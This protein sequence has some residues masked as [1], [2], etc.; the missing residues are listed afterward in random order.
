MRFGVL[1][2]GARIHFIARYLAGASDKIKLIDRVC[3][4][5]S[6]AIQTYTAACN[7]TS[8]APRHII[9]MATHRTIASPTHPIQA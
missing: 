3:D 7:P 4:R 5:L 9:S 1:A 6:R 2:R 8:S